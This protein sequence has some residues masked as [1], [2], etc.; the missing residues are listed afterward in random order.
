[1]SGKDR[2]ALT[3]D[4]GGGIMV[5]N[6]AT[7]SAG[8]VVLILDPGGLVSDNKAVAAAFVLDPD[9]DTV[10]VV[11]TGVVLR[12]VLGVSTAS[13][14][15]VPDNEGGGA[16]TEGDE[17]PSTASPDTGVEERLSRDCFNSRISGGVAFLVDFFLRGSGLLKTISALASIMRAVGLKCLKYHNPGY[18][19]E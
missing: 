8:G 5:D 13:P 2:E 9:G 14:D 7:A 6:K 11:L 12:L 4:P 3:P 1:M 15:T 17:E 18:C 16:L 10:P 19:L